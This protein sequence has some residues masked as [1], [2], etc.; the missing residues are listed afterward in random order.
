MNIYA[1]PETIAFLAD[2][3]N[4]DHYNDHN[5]WFP[6]PLFLLIPLVFWATFVFFGIGARRRWH[7]RSGEGTLRDSFARG[8]IT[9][10]EYRARLAV[11]KETRR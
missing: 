1:H 11:L 9:E 8:E 6:W 2:Y 4:A 3:Y 5:G 10:T 7:G